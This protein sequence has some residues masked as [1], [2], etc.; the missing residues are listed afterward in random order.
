MCKRYTTEI[1]ATNEGELDNIDD[2]RV[3]SEMFPV[4]PTNIYKS[5]LAGIR[6][7]KY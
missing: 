3:H 2:Y 4:S 5:C 1:M 7:Q 6:R